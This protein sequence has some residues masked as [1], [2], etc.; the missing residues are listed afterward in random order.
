ML[1][2]NKG[3]CMPF[4]RRLRKSCHSLLLHWSVL[5]FRTSRSNPNKERENTPQMDTATIIAE[6]EAERDKL[7]SAI[8][9]LQGSQSRVRTLSGKPDG[10][11][12]VIGNFIRQ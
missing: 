8:A 1:V 4:V 5:Q 7:D 12:R 6:L 10:R 11:S 9:A 3:C 2:R